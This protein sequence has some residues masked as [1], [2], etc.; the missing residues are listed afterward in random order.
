MNPAETTCEQ[1]HA[2]LDRFGNAIV[3]GANP[4]PR[5]TI[6]TIIAMRAILFRH[7]PG[8]TSRGVV[9]RH[10]TDISG[11]SVDWPCPDADDILKV[12]ALT[13]DDA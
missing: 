11:S 4:A 3:Q 5:L 7:A 9:C 10:C 2:E 1:A 12:L 8:E 13:G 6:D